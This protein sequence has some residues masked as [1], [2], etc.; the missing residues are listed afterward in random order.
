MPEQEE[1]IKDDGSAS[2]TRPSAE[3][4][5]LQLLPSQLCVAVHTSVAGPQE[6]E[7]KLPL[8]VIEQSPEVSIE[9]AQLLDISMNCCRDGECQPEEVD[10]V[11][12]LLALLTSFD[13]LK[14]GAFT[15]FHFTNTT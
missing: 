13:N 6:G 2:T 15:T 8:P 12:S 11:E 3:G 14:V 1:N 4:H 9:S 5:P 10:H 7:C